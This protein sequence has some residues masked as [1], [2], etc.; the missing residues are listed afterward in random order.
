MISCLSQVLDIEWL[1]S[2]LM[3]LALKILKIL[4]NKYYKYKLVIQRRSPRYDALLADDSGTGTIFI[5]N[6]T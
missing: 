5:L 3:L 2:S 6:S 1:E 4:F